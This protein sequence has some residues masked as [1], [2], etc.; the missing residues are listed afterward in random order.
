MEELT[1]EE[2]ALLWNAIN[3]YVAAC[4]GSPDKFAYGN[5]ERQRAVASCEKA[6][7]GFI[8][9]RRSAPENKALTP[10]EL[11]QMDGEPVWDDY[12]RE[13]ALVL[14]CSSGR[15]ALVTKSGCT[16]SAEVNDERKIYARRP[17]AGK[18]ALHEHR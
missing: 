18:E 7:D 8:Q 6:V 2:K 10:D 14:V 3:R 5:S 15:I 11:W 1:T 16:V 4:H 17:E 9:S 12:N 13:Y